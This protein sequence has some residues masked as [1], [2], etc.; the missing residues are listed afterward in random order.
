MYKL[1]FTAPLY[2]SII[3]TIKT[4][5]PFSLLGPFYI[6]GTKIYVQCHMSL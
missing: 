5:C 2:L 3:T 6:R 1:Q 4:V